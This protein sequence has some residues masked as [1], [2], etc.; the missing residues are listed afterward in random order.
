MFSTRRPITRMFEKT[1]NEAGGWRPKDERGSG[2]KERR[3]LEGQQRVREVGHIEEG[4]TYVSERKRR[5]GEREKEREAT[6]GET[7]LFEQVATVSR[8]SST[9]LL[10]VE[11]FFHRRRLR[12]AYGAMVGVLPRLPILSTRPCSASCGNLDSP[13][14][15]RY[16]TPRDLKGYQRLADQLP[17]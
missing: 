10:T 9:I 3:L 16:A 2:Q 8:V 4:W 11:F 7:L 6:K 13:A 15:D 14:R 1:G 5:G 12:Q 17:T